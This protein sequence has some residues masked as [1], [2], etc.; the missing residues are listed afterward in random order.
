MAAKDQD[1]LTNDLDE[2]LNTP[3]MLEKIKRGEELFHSGELQELI[4]DLDKTLARR[5]YTLS[6]KALHQRQLASKQPRTQTKI[7]LDNPKI[8]YREVFTLCNRIRRALRIFESKFSQ[9]GNHGA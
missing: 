9:A 8:L 2:I 5:K 3:E 1:N 6:D 4:D 7:S